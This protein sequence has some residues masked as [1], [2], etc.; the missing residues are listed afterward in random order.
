[1]EA[2]VDSFVFSGKKTQMDENIVSSQTELLNVYTVMTF[3]RKTAFMVCCFKGD[4]FSTFP[5]LY[6]YSGALLEYL[7]MIYS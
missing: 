4:I 3:Q 2:K 6:L 5:G 1:M 7:C